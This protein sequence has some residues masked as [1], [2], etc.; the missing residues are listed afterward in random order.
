LGKIEWI[1]ARKRYCRMVHSLAPLLRQEF[2]RSGIAIFPAR[3]AVK[4]SI[5]IRN[6]NASRII[7][8]ES[9]KLHALRLRC[10]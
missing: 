7:A 2:Q 1:S 10:F 6:G 3:Q 4:L 8:F 9:C 5:L